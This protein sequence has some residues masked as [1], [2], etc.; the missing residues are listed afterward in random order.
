MTGS[1]ALFETEL[2]HLRGRR[3]FKPRPPN[4]TLLPLRGS[5]QNFRR[6]RGGGSHVGFLTFE[7][8]MQHLRTEKTFRNSV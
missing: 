5:F 6:A 2:V 4:R 3:N 8:I 1:N 7:E